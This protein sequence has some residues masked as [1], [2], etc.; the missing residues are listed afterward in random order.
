MPAT[1]PLTVSVALCTHNGM[2]YVAEQ[3]RS[4]LHQTRPPAQLVLSDDDSTDATVETVNKVIARFRAE[5]PDS[6]ISVTIIENRPALGVVRN[7]EGAVAACTGDLIA[8]SDQDDLWV[9]DRLERM[10]AEFERRPELTLLHTDARLVD[11]DAKPLASRLFDAI[12]FTP[13]EQQ[14]EREG[15]AFELLLKRN[16]VTGAT[17]MF[18]R[19]LLERAL[20]FVDDWVHDEWL[21]M[22]ASVFGTVDFLPDALVDYRQHGANQIGAQKLDARGKLARLQ[23][24]RSERNRRLLSRAEALHDRLTEADAPEKAIDAAARKVEHEKHRSAL[25][26]ARALRI[27]PVIAAAIRGRYSRF[28][29]PRYDLIR[30]LIQ[31][32]R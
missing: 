21:A 22:V 32:D 4:I 18:R 14:L 7:F 20:P 3:V 13:Q 10:V 16:V 28:G 6:G 23:E 26:R 24:P 12:E 30:D 2:P 1:Y 29:R 8:L 9:P 11:G 19:D 31:P 15:R 27:V 17:T 25:P 5:R